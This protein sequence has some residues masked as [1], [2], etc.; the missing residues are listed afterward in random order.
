MR[1]GVGGTGEAVV[2]GDGK[3]GVVEVA[4]GGVG[5]VWLVWQ[6]DSVIARKI[7]A[8]IRKTL[9]FIGSLQSSRYCF[10]KYEIILGKVQAAGA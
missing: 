10:L 1:L 3:G 9:G 7:M 4:G 6:P 8:G 5:V 2:V